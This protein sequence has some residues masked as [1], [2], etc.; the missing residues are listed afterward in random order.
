MIQGFHELQIVIQ[1][2]WI[3]SNYFSP[4]NIMEHI[5]EEANK[6][7]VFLTEK[8]PPGP[9]SRLQNWK[10]TTSEE[11]H[12]FFGIVMLMSR[13]KKLTIAEYWSKDPLIATPQFT[14]YLSRDRFL[15]LLRVL[16]FNDNESQ[17]L[18]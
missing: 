13:V 12:V 14:D 6:Y 16:N 8:L 10:N 1:Q 18:G 15:L 2:F 17:V 7:Y 3:S 5:A 4:Y 11:L 9:K